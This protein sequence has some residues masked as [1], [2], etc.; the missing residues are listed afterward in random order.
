LS[1]RARPVQDAAYVFSGLNLGKAAGLAFAAAGTP[2]PAK[3]IVLVEAMEAE[4]AAEAVR[5]HCAPS[6]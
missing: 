3:L 5:P 6:S 1:F 4:L 2:R